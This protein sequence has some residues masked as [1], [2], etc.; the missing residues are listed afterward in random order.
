MNTERASAATSESMPTI[1]TPRL[2]ACLSA[3]ATAFGSLPAMMIASGF[4]CAAELMIGIC[5]EAPASVGPW[6]R[7]EPPSSLS[8]SVMPECSYSS[9]GLPSCLGIETVLSPVGIF[10]FGSA[11]PPPPEAWVDVSPPDA[12]DSEE[13]LVSP[14]AATTNAATRASAA[15]VARSQRVPTVMGEPPPGDEPS[16]AAGPPRPGAQCWD[17]PPTRPAGSR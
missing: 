8:A 1:L 10:A 9:Y 2:A 12:V 14:H 7:L 5:E 11:A 16:R 15:N 13:L 4:D 6:M 17:R 3:G